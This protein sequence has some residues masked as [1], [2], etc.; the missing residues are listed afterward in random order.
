M[1]TT[2]AKTDVTRPLCVDLDGSLLATDVLW[3]SLVLLAKTKPIKLFVLPV[4]LTKG[5]AYFK[6]QVALNSNLNVD[7]LPIRSDVMSFLK[8]EKLAGRE[9]VLATA[10]DQLVADKIGERFELFTRV[11]AS[12][13]ETNLSGSRKLACL[14]ESFGGTNFDYI[15]D[16]RVDLEIWQATEH[17]ILVEP[18]ADLLREATRV[19]SIRKVFAAKT[20]KFFVFI[21][22]IRVYQWVKN[23]LLFLPL[24]MA[25]KVMEVD[26]VLRAVYAFFAFSFC[27]SSVYVLND[28]LDLESDRKHPKKRKRPFAAGT[29]QIKTGL[30]IV[31]MFLLVSFTIAWTLLPPLFLAALALYL[32]ITTSYSFYFKKILVVDVLILAGLYT[33]RVLAGGI[34]TQIILSTWLLAFSMFFFISLAF[35]KRYSELQLI[36]SHN[37]SHNKS[38]GYN[39][40]DTE[41][42]KSVG[43]TSGYLSMLVLALYIN[44]NEVAAQ[45]RDPTMLW[46]IGPFFF[47]W[48]TR[49]WFKAH[50]G[51]LDDDPIVFTVKDPRSYVIGAIIAIIIVLA[52]KFSFFHDLM[53]G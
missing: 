15:G 39:F 51:R 33:F 26:L 36:Q 1:K 37:G 12:D 47:Y 9:V 44:S 4:W 30:Q 28:L 20:N 18:S 38:R 21:R 41:L 32:V 13:G 43:P 2:S 53:T 22:A 10:T 52:S 35:I 3:E 46:L 40:M 25:H 6:R 45:Y 24:A 29:L 19:S 23:L 34:A 14:T 48:I 42:L 49:I 11:F 7:F 16:A 17:A 8:T 50:R 31:P 27:A 5:K